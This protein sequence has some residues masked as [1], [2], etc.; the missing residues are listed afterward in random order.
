MM[1]AAVGPGRRTSGKVDGVAVGGV[2]VSGM[3]QAKEREGLTI[4]IGSSLLE[5]FI[6]DI[7]ALAIKEIGV[8]PQLIQS[9]P[10]TRV[11]P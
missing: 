11:F 7:A 9:V 2:D 5:N 1:E 8:H 10:G 4:S 3:L 6:K